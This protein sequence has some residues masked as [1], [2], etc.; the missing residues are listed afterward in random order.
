MRKG[1]IKCGLFCLWLAAL[2]WTTHASQALVQTYEPKE[3]LMAS[4]SMAIITGPDGQAAAQDLQLEPAES[5]TQHAVRVNRNIAVTTS[6]ILAGFVLCRIVLLWQR[7][8]NRKK[9]LQDLNSP[10]PKS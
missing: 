5:R 9:L 2:P 6:L 10:E 1:L 4:V 3:P 8:H 7:T